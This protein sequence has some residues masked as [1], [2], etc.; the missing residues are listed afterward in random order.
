MGVDAESARP[1]RSAESASDSSSECSRCSP[2]DAHHMKPEY[3]SAAQDSGS[4]ILSV[5]GRSSIG[6]SLGRERLEEDARSVSDS[7][8]EPEEL[9]RRVL[10][11]G[12]GE[13]CRARLQRRAL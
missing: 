10:G 13:T 11:L 1:D 8:K 4:I 5:S 6:S 7:E 3:A 12:A 2:A 9:R